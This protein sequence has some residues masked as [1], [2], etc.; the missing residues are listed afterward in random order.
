MRVLQGYIKDGQDSGLNTA[1]QQYALDELI[2]L[3]ESKQQKIDV[4]LT[5]KPTPYAYIEWSNSP[6][7]KKAIF[8]AMDA[9]FAALAAIAT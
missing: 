7:G 9:N 8:G 3:T 2:K 1:G 4:E 5:V 6:A